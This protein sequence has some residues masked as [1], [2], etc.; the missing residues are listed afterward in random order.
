[1]NLFKILTFVFSILT[2]AAVAQC[3]IDTIPPVAQTVS[4][5]TAVLT[6]DICGI[7]IYAVDLFFFSADDCTSN[8]SL[9]YTFDDVHPDDDPNWEAQYNSSSK[10][11]N[12]LDVL[13]SPGTITVN[14]W[15]YAGN[16]SSFEIAMTVVAPAS[17][18]CT[19]CENDTIPPVVEFVPDLQWFIPDGET[20]AEIWASDFVFSAKDACTISSDIGY[21][22]SEISPFEDSSASLITYLCED[23]IT[24]PFEV[25]VY[26]WDQNGNYTVGTSILNFQNVA[27]LDC[28]DSTDSLQVMIEG[29]LENIYGTAVSG[30]TAF[31]EDANGNTKATTQISQGK[32]SFETQLHDRFVRVEYNED[33]PDLINLVDLVT[34]QKY[35]L[36][37]ISLSGPQA[38][39]ADLDGDGSVRISDLKM[40]RDHL[41]QLDLLPEEVINHATII[42]HSYIAHS[43][44]TTYERIDLSQ[45]ENPV[46]V[47]IQAGNLD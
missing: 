43:G 7:R 18:D 3:E 16:N 27:D 28:D 46:F 41:L 2:T 39:A 23:L 10:P 5:S 30:G 8:D 38:I 45:N 1:M 26:V 17:L 33:L 15:D 22:F 35:L 32:F 29:R 47:L 9:R 25:E 44:I 34:L 42:D 13:N 21:S 20:E 4:V 14:V 40:M 24:S 36:G 11:I 37:L 6:D 12:C 19:Q 31:L